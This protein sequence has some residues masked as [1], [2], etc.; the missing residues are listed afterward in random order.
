MSAARNSGTKLVSLAVAATVAA[1]GIGTVYLPFIADRDKV[2]GLH[3]EGEMSAAERRQ[4]ERALSEMGAQSRAS[5]SN[6][7]EENLPKSNSMWKRMNQ[8]PGGSSR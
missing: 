2:R 8:S 5:D 1:V 4:Y 6:K 7:K 3:E